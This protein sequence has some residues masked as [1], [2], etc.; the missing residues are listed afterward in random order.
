MDGLPLYQAMGLQRGTH[1]HDSMDRNE[2][3][4]PHSLEARGMSV[5]DRQTRGSVWESFAAVAQAEPQPIGCQEH[6]NCAISLK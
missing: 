5:E 3:T 4:L 2:K 6:N 1:R